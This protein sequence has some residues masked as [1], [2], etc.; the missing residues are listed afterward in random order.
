[1]KMIKL[2]L[3]LPALS[4]LAACVSTARVAVNPRAD[5]SVIRRVAV[6]SFNGPKGDLAA[7][8]LTQSLIAHGADVIE[9]QRF[10][11]VIKEQSLSASGSLDP[12]TVKQL[13]KLLG[14][15]AIF[16]GTVAESTPQTTYLVSES[17]NPRITTV[18]QVSGNSVHSEGSVL[19]MPNSQILSTT[20]N[21]SLVSRMVDVQ[22][23]SIM[24]AASMSYEGFDIPSAMA[25]IAESFTRSLAP[26][27]TLLI[28]S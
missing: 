20:A 15:D 27:W 12:S 1:M 9:R 16:V 23:G 22:T 25:G 21:V 5:F 13:G 24:W 8:M 26:I 4:L 28:P 7:D 11:A 19:G 10:D 3:A 14:V 6:M 17:N 2:L 18:N